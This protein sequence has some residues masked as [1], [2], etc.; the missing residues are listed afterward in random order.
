[1][2]I[3]RHLLNINI[4]YFDRRRSNMTTN[5]TTTSTITASAQLQGLHGPKP[6]PLMINKNSSKITKRIKSPVIVYLK[7][8]KV[9]HVLPH[10]FMQT[11]Q[12]LTGKPNASSSHQNL[13]WYS[14]VL[15]TIWVLLSRILEFS[16][17]HYPSFVLAF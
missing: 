15:Y 11:V 16:Q 4:Q 12:Q 17:V 3:L 9:I 13:W 6:A 7:S 10:E 2:Q 1:M 8:P 5:I 14:F